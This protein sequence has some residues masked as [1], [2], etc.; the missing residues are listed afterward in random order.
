MSLRLFW[1]VFSLEARTQMSYRGNFWINAVAGFLADFGV[2]YFVWRAVYDESGRT[3]IGGRT[4]D[5]T[6]LYYLAVILVGK[7]VR[8]REFEA[9]ISTDIYE[10]ALTRYLLFPVSYVGYKYAQRLGQFVP[11]LVQVALF[12]AGM[13]LFIRLPAG[14]GVTA[15]SAAM[16][17][18]A[19]ALASVLYYLTDYVVQQVAFWA[20]N[21]WSLDVGKW[22]VTSLLGGWLL[23]LSVYPDWARPVLDVL[24]FRFLF[25]FPAR[26]LLGEIG[27][28]EWGRGLALCAVW[29]S[30][31]LLAGRVVWRRGRLQYTGVGI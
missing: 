29:A 27:G 5:A 28:A 24:P 31:F 26:V 8:G 12:G 23:P 25:D 6:V 3:F 21:V 14:T 7:L 15:A 22:F 16:A 19:I 30:L 20:D 9:S 11:A 4:F 10:G 17:L 1:H 2:T 18:P 13:L